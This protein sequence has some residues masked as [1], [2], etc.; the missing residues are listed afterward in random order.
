MTKKNIYYSLLGTA[1]AKRIL[2]DPVRERI[3][4]MRARFDLRNPIPG[5][6]HLD[7]KRALRLVQTFPDPEPKPP[8]P[9]PYRGLKCPY[10]PSEEAAWTLA[11][12][13]ERWK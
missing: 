12:P 11:S 4:T 3:Q 8:M 7:T 5:H 13:P 6:P 2:L 9:E 1:K 10:K